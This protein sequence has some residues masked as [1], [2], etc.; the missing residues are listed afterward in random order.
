M[1]GPTRRQALLGVAAA[2]GSQVL[3]SR[4]AAARQ[5][6]R[7]AVDLVRFAWG[8]DVGSPTPFQVSTA[9]PAGAVLL[10]LIYDTL[11]WKDGEGIIPWLATEWEASADGLVYT[12]RLVDGATWHDGQPL[13][14]ADVAFSFEYYARHPYTWMT[15]E[16]VA[17]AAAIDE[18]TARI[19]LKRPYAP[20]LEDIAGVVPIV[21]RHVWEP[22]AD[23]ITYDRADRFVGSGPFSLAEYDQTEGAYRLSAHDGYW[24]G[25]PLA[26]EWRQL[27]VPN[28]ARVLV[29]QQGE[30][31]VSYTPDA[32]V[33][34]VLAGEE[35]LRVFETAPHSIVRLAINTERAPLDR[36]EVRQAIAYALDRRLIAETVTRGPA[37]VGSAGVIP[38]ET[39]WYN[40][41]LR[42][43]DHAPERAQE[44]L[45]GERFT[46]DLIAD[47]TSREPE[48]MRPMLAAVGITLN[49][50]LVDPPTR[51]ALLDAGEFQ[52]AQVQH[53]GVGGDPDFLR[54]WYAGEEA[55]AFAKGSIFQNDEFTMLGE[56][57]AATLAPEERRALVDRMQEILAEE[58]PTIALYHRRFYWVHDPAVFT[59]MET[60]GGL[61]NGIPFP[62]NKLALLET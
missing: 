18:Q 20:F 19:T 59:P 30:A 35:R 38:P 49:V 43:Y 54:R 8:T 16:V 60:W 10:S 52:L 36:V 2:L 1:R 53:I 14:A 7:P 5:P 61:M 4:P 41:A 51:I 62:N 31:D 58:L 12:F 25:R 45:G 13:T 42:Q 44:L 24:R 46:L 39:P 50:Q 11:T 47:A 26:R 6:E 9:G 40:P 57:Q 27:T 48:L 15:T 22:V 29:V 33:R 32:S 23:P 21:P 28:E 34:E 56:E 17:T 55:N 37:I 3:P